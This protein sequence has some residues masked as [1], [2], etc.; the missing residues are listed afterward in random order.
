MRSSFVVR[1]FSVVPL[2]AVSLLFVITEMGGHISTAR[3]Q[4]NPSAT[5]KKANIALTT[6]PSPAQKGSN[7]I[8]VKLTD[9]AGQPIA[10]AEV[11]V[12]FFM[13][14]MPS[15][16]MAAMKTVIKGT[17]KGGGLYEGKG[18]LGS[19]G[20]WQVTIKVQQNGQAIATK[21]LTVKAAGGM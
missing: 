18:D 12:T 1:V 5:R 13:P 2:L 20:M 4:D 11:T 6:D 9:Q 15:M 16:N 19:G 17:D 10:G 14:A 21:K 8:R 7:T 3:A